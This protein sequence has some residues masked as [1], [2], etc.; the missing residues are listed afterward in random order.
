MGVYSDL[1]IV[2][3]TGAGDAF[4]A[5]FLCGAIEGR[6]PEECA[7]LGTACSAFAIQAA[8]ATAGMK[9]LAEVRAF[10]ESRPPL[11]IRYDLS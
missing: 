8:G 3:T 2:E 4:C 5:G 10:I 1:H 9:S 11:E 7:T 6:P